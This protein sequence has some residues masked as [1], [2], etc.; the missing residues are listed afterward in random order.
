MHVGTQAHLFL[1]VRQSQQ[2]NNAMLAARPRP[3]PRRLRRRVPTTQWHSPLLFKLNFVVAQFRPPSSLIKLLLKMGTILLRALL[4]L[5]AALVAGAF[6]SMVPAGPALT[7]LRHSVRVGGGRS[8]LPGVSL[9]DRPP[10]GVRL[11][12]QVRSARWCRR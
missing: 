4:L 11:S 1:P 9:S 3:A 10:R 12:F 7:P 2:S 8:H 6:T 5:I